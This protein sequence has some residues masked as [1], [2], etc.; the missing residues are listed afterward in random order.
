MSGWQVTEKP[1]SPAL[2]PFDEMKKEKGGR[3]F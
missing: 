2:L 1:S 3:W